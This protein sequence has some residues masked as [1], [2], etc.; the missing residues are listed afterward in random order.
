MILADLTKG[1]A[2]KLLELFEHPTFRDI[3]LP[4]IQGEQDLLLRQL[5]ESKDLEMDAR[6]KGRIQQLTDFVGWQLHA[7]AI[8][9]ES[10]DV[11]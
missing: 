8:A 10:P 6:I 1:Q 2:I 11:M 4:V 5:I 3:I 7:H 9:S